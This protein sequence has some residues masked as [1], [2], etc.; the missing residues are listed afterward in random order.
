MS[1][2]FRITAIVAA[3]LACSAMAESVELT[4][5]AASNVSFDA[6]LNTP[7]GSDSDSDSSSISGT[8]TVELDAYGNPTQITLHDYHAAVDQTL[9]MSFDLGFFGSV[10]VAV[11]DA[12]ADYSTPGTPTGPVAVAGDTSFYF[13]A[14][15][16]DLTGTG[17]ATGDIFAIGEINETF[18][19]SDFNPFINDFV[20]SVSVDDGVV[21]LAGTIAFSGSGE[22]MT[23]VTLDMEGTL[24]IAATGQAPAQCP[25][26]Y[27]NDGVA[28][29]FD[30]LEFLSD[31]NTMNPA[32][33]IN[34]DTVFDFFDVLEFLSNF[35]TGCP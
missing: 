13:P 9:N 10:D 33:D 21:T 19:L 6:T 4:L 23:G 34:N 28:D 5:T 25:A 27:N 16:T 29:F 30:V 14:V 7:V 18:V 3:G 24:T 12:S 35:A 15:S 20:G 32:A 17:T 11:P 22:V 1:P 2:M 31:F 26:D 8:I